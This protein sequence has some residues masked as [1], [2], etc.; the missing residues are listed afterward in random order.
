MRQRSLV[1]TF[2]LLSSQAAFADESAKAPARLDLYTGATYLQSAA[3]AGAAAAVGLRWLPIA[4]LAVSADLGYGLQGGPDAYEDRWW[5]IPSLALVIPLGTASL[6]LGAGVGVGTVS[7]YASWPQYFA[8]PFGP[9]WHVTT[10][11]ARGHATFALPISR[12]LALFARVEVASLLVSPS[13]GDDIVWGG[14]WIGVQI[15]LI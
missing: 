4:H 11:A 9:V 3:A 5:A 1:F 10:A 12:S 13:N 15:P 14:L 8:S 7:G 6:D 2:L